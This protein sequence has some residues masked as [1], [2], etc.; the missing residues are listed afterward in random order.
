MT[1]TIPALNYVL[2]VELVVL[3]GTSLCNL[4]CTYCDL[5]E[6]SRKTKAVMSGALIERFFSQLFTS[7]P[8]AS[9][10]TIL[11]H[12]GEPL[13]QSPIYYDEAIDQILRLRQKLIGS[14]SSIRFGIQTNGTLIDENWCQFFLRHADHLEVG[15]SCDGPSELHDLFRVDWAGKVSHAKTLRGMQLLHRHGIKYKL[16]GV[17]TRQTLAKPDEFYKFFF[18]RRDELTG[19][20]FNILASATSTKSDLSYSVTDRT[21]YQ[22]FY[23]RMLELSQASCEEGYPFEIL[24]FAQGAARILCTKS[25][26]DP[27]F[28]EEAIAP[29]RS[30]NL[31][32]QGHVTTFYAGLSSMTLP[33]EYGDGCGLSLGNIWQE[34]LTKMIGSEK[35]R[36]MIEDLAGSAETCRTYCEY[37]SVCP[38]GFE[39][40]KKQTHGTFRAHETSECV[41]H[42][43]TLIDV[44]LEDIQHHANPAVR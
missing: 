18:E 40:L 34:E 12:S 28:S 39:I 16:I 25:A 17:V 4:N 26:G 21:V 5:S 15:V 10:V 36:R 24:N 35:M 29:L 27:S 30:V 22:N 33:D 1:L 23:R 6:R 43:K 14:K 3:Q 38:G 9:E 44:L 42:V 32:A 7:V 8:L 41:I 19:F 2:P 13:T 11:W 37:F 31:D 20:H